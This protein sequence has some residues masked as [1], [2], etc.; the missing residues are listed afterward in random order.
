[1]IDTFLDLIAIQVTLVFITDISGVVPNILKAISRALTH[2]KVETTEIR[3]THILKCSLCQ[4]WWC[5]LLYLI[6]THTLSLPWVA[7]VGFLAYMSK[8][9]CSLYWLVDEKLN[10]LLK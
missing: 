5:G 2:G 7:V 3:Y 4:T 6:L 9:I 8:H 10:N 1:M